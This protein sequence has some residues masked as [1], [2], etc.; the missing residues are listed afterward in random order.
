MQW[1]TTFDAMKSSPWQVQGQVQDAWQI[2][3]IS[4]PLPLPKPDFADNEE[5]KQQY[6]IALGQGLDVFNAGL[7][8]FNDDVSKGLWVSTNWKNDP[9]V[10]A[11]KDAYLKALKKQAKPLDKEELLEE[12]LEAAR[13]SEEDKDRV[14]FYKLYSEIA[15][16]IGKVLIDASTTNNS[17]TQNNTTQIVLVKGSEPKTIEAPNTNIK[18]KISNSGLPELKLVGGSR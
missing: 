9:I 16:Y 7:K 13:K 12:V 10:N 11:A 6:G 2:T 17:N 5:L 15:G 4:E 3:Q 1:P 14:S 18:S 8:I